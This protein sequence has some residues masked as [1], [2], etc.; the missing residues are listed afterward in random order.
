MTFAEAIKTAFFQKYATFNGRA[1][2]SEF[3]YFG[4]FSSIVAVIY[5]VLMIIVFVVCLFII[6]SAATEETAI[7]AFIAMLVGFFLLFCIFIVPFILPSI[8]ACVRRLHDT[9]RSGWN[10]L[11]AL[12]PFVGIFI[13]IAYLIQP[14]EP[15]DN[16]YGPYVKE[17]P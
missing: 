13:V 3:Q 5:Y 10:L 11:L 4:L 9:G 14:S 6:D 2:R 8:A 15:K 1:T 17:T 16:Q 7:I 12:I